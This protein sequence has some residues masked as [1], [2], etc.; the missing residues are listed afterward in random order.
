MEF[1]WLQ[2][3]MPAWYEQNRI[4]ERRASIEAFDLAAM[5]GERIYAYEKNRHILAG[6]CAGY[7]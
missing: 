6:A 1:F 2:E 3:W 5:K 7:G 4:P